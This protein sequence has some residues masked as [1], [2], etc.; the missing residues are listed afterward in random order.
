MLGGNWEKIQL[1][2]CFL[3]CKKIVSGEIYMLYVM[4]VILPDRCGD[5]CFSACVTVQTMC[6]VIN[7]NA[8]ILNNTLDQI[9]RCEEYV[10]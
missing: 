5:F 2:W 7:A 4:E 3:Y 1:L 10:R 6:S 9:K 8:F